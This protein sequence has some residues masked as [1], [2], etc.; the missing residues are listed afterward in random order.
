MAYKILWRNLAWPDDRDNLS[1]PNN[2]FKLT[3]PTM[4]FKG[5]GSFYF[6]FEKA[7]NTGLLT[8][9]HHTSFTS[10][11]WGQQISWKHQLFL[12]LLMLPNFLYYNIFEKNWDRDRFNTKNWAYMWISCGAVKL[13][14][15]G[16]FKFVKTRA[17]IMRKNFSFAPKS[18]PNLYSFL[19]IFL[20]KLK[21]LFWWCSLSPF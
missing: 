18:F 4:Q 1:W 12:R 8:P 2:T 9:M 21:D 11:Q 20:L 3:P 7:N 5:K 16:C 14:R 19:C 6:Y 10:I 13:M 17:M 15:T